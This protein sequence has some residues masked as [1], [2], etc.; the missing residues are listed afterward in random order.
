MI[1]GF[2]VGE[3]PFVRVRVSLPQLSM[4]D[5]ETDLL[6]DT[7]SHVTVFQRNVLESLDVAADAVVALPPSSSRGFGGAAELVAARARLAFI[8]DERIFSLRAALSTKPNE[9]DLPSV[10]GMDF[11]SAFRLTVSMT[12]N[13]VELQPTF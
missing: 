6:I 3:S 10:L 13:L 9:G 8:G 12:E 5:A 7:G 11:I 1:R 4:R 2:F